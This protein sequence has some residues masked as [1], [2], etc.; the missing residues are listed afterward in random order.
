PKADESSLTKNVEDMEVERIVD[1]LKK[2]G[3]VKSRA[4]RLIGL[5]PRQL[6]YRI[7]KYGISFDK[8]WRDS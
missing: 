4:A 7:S 2:C 3:W 1:A 6:D 8:P 5:T